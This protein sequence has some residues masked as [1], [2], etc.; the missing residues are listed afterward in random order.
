MVQNLSFWDSSLIAPIADLLDAAMHWLAI[1]T[2]MRPSFL[3]RS[4]TVF[5]QKTVMHA[6]ERAYLMKTAMEYVISLRYP[7][8]QKLKH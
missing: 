8:A 1:T 2:P 5:I 7:V 3:I 6:M 4:G